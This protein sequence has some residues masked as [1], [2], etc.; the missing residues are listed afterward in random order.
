MSLEHLTE[1]LFREHLHS[2]FRAEVGG[3][4][5]ELELV[6]V[7]GDKSGLPK[8]EGV[9]RFSIYLA[10]PGPLP[11]SIYTLEHEQLGRMEI[12]IVPVAQ[13][14]GRFRYEAVFSRITG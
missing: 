14:G 11:Q 5:V 10:G 7:V 9:E 8:L 13:E 6:E 1:E 4:G 2:K 12:F 3:Q